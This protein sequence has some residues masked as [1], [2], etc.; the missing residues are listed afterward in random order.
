M[1]ADEEASNATKVS[2]V[3]AKVASLFIPPHLPSVLS[4]HKN[5]RPFAKLAN[6]RI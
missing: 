6:D 2:S 4:R 1:Q 5:N 3:A